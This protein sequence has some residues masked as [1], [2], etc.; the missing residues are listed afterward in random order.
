[1]ELKEIFYSF[2]NILNEMSPYILLGF[3]IAGVLH[4]FVKEATLTRHLSGNGWKSVAKAAAIGIPLPLCSCGVLPT[5]VSLNRQGASKAS[6]TSFL[7]ATPQTGVDSIAAT[8]SL[9]GLPFALI[10]P[11][12]A[13]TGAF[14]GGLAVGKFAPDQKS[15]DQIKTTD[16][17]AAG[18][19]PLFRKIYQSVRYGFTDMVDTMGKWLVI[20]LV[21]ATLITIFVPDSLFTG[22]ME[23]PLLAMLLMVVIAIPMYICATGSIP[24]AMSLMLKGLSPGVAFV[25][26]MAGPAA[27]FASILILNK[28]QGKKATAIYV[29]SVIITAIVFGLIIDYLLPAKWFELPLIHD[30]HH[31]HGNLGWFETACSIFLIILLIASAIRSIKLSNNNLKT[32]NDMTQTFKIA[33]MDCNHCRSSVEK[34][35]N[36]VSGVENVEVSLAQKNAVVTGDFDRDKVMEAVRLAGFD[37]EFTEI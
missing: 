29:G 3:I 18:N 9:L 22:L 25:L 10:R 30:M 7:I 23:Y 2:I 24:I 26:L 4:V 12:A 8:Y 36:S 20:G 21:I 17:D 34:A 13:L 28:T 14:F 5:A 15:P 27:N 1:M 16:N 19:D 33:G 31:M 11:I 37:I 35:I 6:T 32:T